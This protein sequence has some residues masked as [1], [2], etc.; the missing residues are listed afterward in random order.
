[1]SNAKSPGNSGAL[2]NIE[3]GKNKWIFTQ[4]IRQKLL[5]QELIQ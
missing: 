1:M 4:L 3:G 5:I 2:I